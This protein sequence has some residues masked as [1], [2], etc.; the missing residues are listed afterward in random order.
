MESFISST[1]HF[2]VIVIGS[3]PGGATLAAYLAQAG[4]V[5]LVIEKQNFPRYHIG[6][7]LTGMAAEILNEFGLATELERRWFPRKGGVKV[8]GKDA[9]NEFFVPVLQPTWQVRRAE[10]DDML[11]QN[12]IG[13]GARHQPGTVKKILHQ[14]GK[15]LGVSYQP[16]GEQVLQDVTAR[17]VVDASGH[18]TVLS[19]QGIAGPLVYFDEF[20]RQV[21]IFTQFRHARR[22]PGLMG[23]N[24]FLFYSEV[25]HW[26]WFIPVSPDVVSVGIVIP[27]SQVQTCGGAEAAWAWGLENINPE[28]GWRVRGCERVEEI[29]TITNYAYNVEPFVG[30]GWLCVGDAHR[31]M[32]PI[33]S[34]GVSFS[35]LE[36]RAASQAILRTMQTGDWR[37]PFTEYAA[38]CTR[39]QDVALDVIRY[40]WKFPVF[41]GYQTRG[42]TRKD[43]IRLLG[44]DCHT[45]EETPIVQVMRQTLAKYGDVAR[46][47][48]NL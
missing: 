8:I 48:V 11:L 39:G 43:I 1:K 21:A 36:A 35:M 12:A 29:R 32:D 26:A 41:F 28:L 16:H 30:D 27:T 9:R 40:F 23:E 10:F 31:F 14:N 5:V 17:F 38:F 4:L 2:D 44:S 22:D 45:P 47:N 33:F 37:G 7:S 15:V 6:E 25:H 34:F 18:G 20:S 46:V 3:G 24:T 42:K 13:L 19:R